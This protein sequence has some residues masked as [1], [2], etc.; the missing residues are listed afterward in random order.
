MKSSDAYTKIIKW[1]DEDQFYL[2]H[3]PELD[4]GKI[5][6]DDNDE[7]ALYADLSAH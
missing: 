4:F 3:C 6:R 1:S 2:A 7:A 5:H